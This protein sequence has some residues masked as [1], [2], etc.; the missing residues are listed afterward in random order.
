MSKIVALAHDAV[1]L[2]ISLTGVRVEEFSSA[3]EAEKRCEE[4]LDCP[5]VSL[6]NKLFEKL[7]YLLAPWRQRIPRIVQYRPAS[8]EVLAVQVY[9]WRFDLRYLRVES[10]LVGSFQREYDDLNA[11]SFH[12]QYLVHDERF[13]NAR[14][15]FYEIAYFQHLL[16]QFTSA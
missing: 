3:T 12:F 1:A 4:L 7:P 10:S 2:N 5:I 16:H 6:H 13:G 15:H 14:V 9:H 11:P 8:P